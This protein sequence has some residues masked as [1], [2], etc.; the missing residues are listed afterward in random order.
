MKAM[1][2][3]RLG[4]GVGIRG[5]ELA[6]YQIECAFC[7]ERGNWERVFHAEKRKPGSDKKLNFDVYKCGNCAG[8]AHVLWS[9]TEG[10]FAGGL[11]A[12]KVLPWPIM[13]K[14]QPSEQWPLQVQRFWTQAHQSHN[15]EIW[16]AA[17]VMARS[18]LQVALREQGAAG[19]SLKDQVDSLADKGLLP[20][21]MNDWATEVRLLG[22]EAAHPEV[23]ETEANPQDVSDALEF[24]DQLL[25]YFYDLPAA[26]RRYRERRAERT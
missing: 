21:A 24:L 15:R 9:A 26:I 19:R 3:W 5:L 8:Y 4:E 17:S 23:D 18:A 20:P 6:L 25:N 2:W 7:N 12:Y 11:H 16:D 1:G 22:N 10:A 13:D 14:P